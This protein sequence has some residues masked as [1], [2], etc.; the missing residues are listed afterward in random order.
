[1]R[2]PVNKWLNPTN[3]IWMYQNL[4]SEEERREREEG[5]RKEDGGR[6]KEEGGRRKKEGERRKEG[7]GRGRREKGG[8]RKDLSVK[9]ELRLA[10]KNNR[11][12]VHK[13]HERKIQNPHGDHQESEHRVGQ[14]EEENEGVSRGRPPKKESTCTT[15]FNKARVISQ[16]KIREIILFVQEIEFYPKLKLGGPSLMV[17]LSFCFLAQHGVNITKFE[18]EGTEP[19]RG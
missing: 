6:R 5:G 12:L 4:V 14:D 13:V 1:M 9:G 7:E 17:S 2:T 8:W 15:I 3:H 19:A 10:K 16:K 18:S 11:V